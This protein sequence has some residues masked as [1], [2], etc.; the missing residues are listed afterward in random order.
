MPRLK[1]GEAQRTHKEIIK[2]RATITKKE[3]REYF[4]N[5]HIENNYRAYAEY[6]IIDNR[7]KRHSSKIDNYEYVQT[8]HKAK[9]KELEEKIQSLK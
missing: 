4:K 9:I 5:H 6:F 1:K 3:I 7:N 2:L 8:L